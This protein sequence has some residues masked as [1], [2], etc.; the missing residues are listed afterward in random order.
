MIPIQ[1][2][3]DTYKVMPTL[4]EHQLRVAAI[5]LYI[6]EH[7]HE[8]VDSV[9]VVSALLLHDMGN[10]IKFDFSIFPQFC[11]PE[12]VAYW[13]RIQ[14]AYR[15]AYGH[16]EHH[17]HML[18]AE[19]LGMEPHILEY[20]DAVG[21]STMQDVA[22]SDSLEKKICAY[23]DQRV[24]PFGVISL[25]ERL[26]EGRKRYGISL[27]EARMDLVAAVFDI[28]AELTRVTGEYIADI[29][30]ST[31]ASYKKRV[32]EMRLSVHISEPIFIK[33]LEK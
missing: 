7:C 33:F 12:G 27:K 3:Y 32:A 4:R 8:D 30:E 2:I 26:E 29:N 15:L 19:E 20:I 5:G 17:A 1:E 21:F 23:A 22:L 16:N 18:I 13:E 25:A 14:H 9:A 31:I 10:C 6:A 11:E 28:E 24:G